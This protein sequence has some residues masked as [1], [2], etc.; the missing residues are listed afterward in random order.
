MR[1]TICGRCGAD[2]AKTLGRAET[3]DP[4]PGYWVGLLNCPQCLAPY[5]Y[6][7]PGPPPPPQPGLFEEKP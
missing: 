4:D 6:M 5:V 7:R 1:P 3:W 2:L